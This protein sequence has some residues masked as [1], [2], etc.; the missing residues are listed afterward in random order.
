VLNALGLT[1]FL[2]RLVADRRK[3]PQDDLTTRLV[4]AED[5][6]DRLSEAELIAMLMLILFAGHETTV[7]LI[8]SG[9][10]ALLQHP[11]QF[12]KLKADRS[13]METAVEEMLRYTN[14]VQH[15]AYR[16]NLE[17]MAI[18]GTTI[19]AHS[20]L[21]VCVAA[22]NRDESVF[23]NAASLDIT[24]KPNRHIAF[25]FGIHYCLGAPLARMEARIAFNTLM[26]RF[27]DLQLAVPSEQLQWR[28]MP[29]LRGLTRLPV[30][31]RG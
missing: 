18:G 15:I 3:N 6:G 20:A 28:G 2:K 23:E 12:E 16:Y 27:P 7:N 11:D 31:L 14:P 9:T 17:A 5:G 21:Q 25:G 22:A 10:L 19:P 30:R 1:R 24:R 4:Q 13:L 8:G 29:A 26:D